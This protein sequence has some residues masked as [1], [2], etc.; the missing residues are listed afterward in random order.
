M[1]VIGRAKKDL[2]LTCAVL[3][4]VGAAGPAAAA[5]VTIEEIVKSGDPVPGRS[6]GIVF[7]GGSYVQ[8]P[9]IN[10]L[11]EVVFR[12]KSGPSSADAE[13]IYVYRPGQPLTVLVDTAGNRT[14]E[15]PGH[16]GASFYQFVHT[17]ANNAPLL[18]NVGDVVFW[19]RF[20]DPSS[21]TYPYGLFATTTTGGPIVKLVDTTTSVPAQDESTK[22][23]NLFIDP[24]G[25]MP[26]SLNDSG[27]VVFWGNFNLSGALHHGVY[28]TTVNGGTPVLL[29]DSTQT[30]HPVDQPSTY[31]FITVSSEF[32]IN[33][34]GTVA[35]SGQFRP[36]TALL[37]G[38]FTVPV[39][40]GDVT[41]E[42]FRLWPA[43]GS[44]TTDHSYSDDF[45]GPDINNAGT[46]V[47]RN[48]PD[49]GWGLYAVN[50]SGEHSRIVDNFGDFLVPNRLEE[51]YFDVINFATINEAGQMGCFARVSNSGKSNDQ[52][53]YAA[54]VGDGSLQVVADKESIPPGL[55][56]LSDAELR[57]F[58]GGGSAAINDDGHMAFWASGVDESGLLLNGVYFYDACAMEPV[59]IVDSTTAQ[60]DLGHSG[61]FSPDLYQFGDVRSGHYRSINNDNDVAFLAKFGGSTS[62]DFG[63]YIAHVT[64]EEFT[65]AIVVSAVKHTVGSGAHP[66]STKTPLEDIEVCAYD[67]SEGSCALTDCGGI[68]HQHYACIALGDL[69]GD[70]TADTEPCDPVNCCT[71]DGSGVCTIDLLPGDYIV[72]S[73][74][75]TKTVLPDPLGVSAGDLADGEVMYK[76]LQQIERIDGKKVPGK[77]TRLT[78][79]ELLIIEPEFMLWEDTTELYPFVFDSIGD[80]GVTVTVE[81]PDGFVADY[82]SL[83][84][85]V[86]DELEAVQFAVTE[87]GSDLVPTQT[88]FW[89]NHK[90][91]QRIVDSNV[92]IMLTPDYAQSRGFDVAELR[93]KGLI[94]ERLGA[95]GQGH[96]GAR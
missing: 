67:K 38:I 10:D 81:P 40:G 36:G 29:A 15:V 42:A 85:D 83:S 27:E 19:A 4:V 31:T 70:G 26:A 9:S 34:S 5:T 7:V 44:E 20:H 49:G 91:R 30:I 71:T 2:Q 63:M 37:T 35:F 77:T 45:S 95:H 12:A 23:S 94:K 6:A 39:T 79:S 21:G 50:A 75:A 96:G 80:W 65:A 78:G 46:I 89:V 53:I 59:R 51:A 33:N 11:G 72:I 69:D 73:A 87:V 24:L 43:P 61:A 74:D 54:D 58:D 88:T 68:S 13:G 3:L 56:P 84:E 76:H 17:T 18:N 28:G 57:Y 16:D 14:T 41:T 55:N 92:D 64:T 86:A 60:A 32:A 25:N 47:F 52:G 66:G 90:G 22:F 8:P 48:R 1:N 82:D 93:A 62:S